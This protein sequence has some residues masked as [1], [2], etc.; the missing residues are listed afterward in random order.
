MKKGINYVRITLSFDQETVDILHKLAE[1]WK[2]TNSSS[3]V[4][5]AIK[6]FAEK[7]NPDGGNA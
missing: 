5:Q 4:R 7:H 2:F 1:D 3:V 6:E